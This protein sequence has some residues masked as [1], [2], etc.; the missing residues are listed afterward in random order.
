MSNVIGKVLWRAVDDPDLRRRMLRDLGNA[1][2]EEG[3]ILSDSEMA[4]LRDC[5]ETVPRHSDNALRERITA[6]ARPYRR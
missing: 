4:I 6:M 3:F 2:A 1:L 5:W